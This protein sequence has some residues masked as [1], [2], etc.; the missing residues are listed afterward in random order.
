MQRDCCKLFAN[1][2]PI[3][4]WESILVHISSFNLIRAL[5]VKKKKVELFLG[6]G[7]QLQKYFQG[8]EEVFFQGFGENT[9]LF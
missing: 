5:C 1:I 6:I 8:A 3:S 7:E 4:A 2:L 9:T